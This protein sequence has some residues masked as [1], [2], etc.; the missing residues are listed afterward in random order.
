MSKKVEVRIDWANNLA[1]VTRNC[2]E[3]Y[4]RKLLQDKLK[5]E[6]SLKGGWECFLLNRDWDSPESAPNTAKY[7]VK[8]PTTGLR[9]YTGNGISDSDHY[10]FEL[11]NWYR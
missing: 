8:S 7:S 2:V 1:Y 4:A 10:V 5:A 11:T 6:S 3:K 9:T